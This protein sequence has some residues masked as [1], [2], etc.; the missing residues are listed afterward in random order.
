MLTS[1]LRHSK[2]TVC[3]GSDQ[4]AKHLITGNSGNNHHFIRLDKYVLEMQPWNLFISNDN[5]K[6]CLRSWLILS[7]KDVHWW[8]TGPHSWGKLCFSCEMKTTILSDWCNWYVISS[9]LKNLVALPLLHLYILWHRDWPEPWKKVFSQP[10]SDCHFTSRSVPARLSL[11]SFHF[12]CLLCFAKVTV[13]V[14]RLFL[15]RA[16]VQNILYLMK[17]CHR[18][19]ACTQAM[20]WLH[21]SMKLWN[22]SHN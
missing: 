8:Y 6:I 18:L 1:R 21:A 16:F 19:R 4:C 15:Y 14:H 10:S 22:L 11:P 3:K 20:K 7:G 5:M 12:L 9:Q 2:A 13:K 17:L